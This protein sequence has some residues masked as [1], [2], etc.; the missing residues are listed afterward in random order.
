MNS[1]VLQHVLRNVSDYCHEK[2]VLE[3][4]GINNLVPHDCVNAYAMANYLVKT[5]GFSHYVSVAPEGYIYGYFFNKI[6]I[7]PLAISVDYP[8][9]KA[10]TLD[11]L[12]PIAG[13]TVLIIEDDVIGG[14]TLKIVVSEL[15]KFK[16]RRLSLFLGHSK[17]F[18]HFENIQPEIESTY[19]AEDTL[20][21]DEYENRERE[22]ITEFGK[23]AIE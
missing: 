1:I 9:K 17:I 7:H 16:P 13:G 3:A 4:P 8:P 20:N 19:I 11:D 23:E 22:F 10:S 2:G 15:L 6:G 5:V 14:G 12:L 18:Q 21:E